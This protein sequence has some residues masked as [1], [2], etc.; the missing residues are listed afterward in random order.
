MMSSRLRSTA[1]QDAQD[2]GISTIHQELALIPHLSV[3]ENVFLNREQRKI[4]IIG[5]VDFGLMNQQAE[6]ILKDLGVE[7]PGK[8]IVKELTVAAQ[9]MVEIAKALSINANLILMDEP[10]SA[11]FQQRSRCPVCCDATAEGKRRLGSLHQPPSGRSPPIC[12]P[13]H[14]HERRSPRRHTAYCRSN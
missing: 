6:T 3:A 4:P 8:V 5:M 11:L 1:P 7:V 13:G 14:Y 2:M 10:T 9:Q 12:R